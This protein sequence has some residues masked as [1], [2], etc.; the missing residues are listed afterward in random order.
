[1]FS[2]FNIIFNKL[3]L[4]RIKGKSEHEVPFLELQFPRYGTLGTVNTHLSCGLLAAWKCLV[5]RTYHKWL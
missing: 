3:N 4:L 2:R 5:D 1:M